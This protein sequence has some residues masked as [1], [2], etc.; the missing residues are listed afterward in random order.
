MVKKE[1]SWNILKQKIGV[2]VSVYSNPFNSQNATY[3]G[4]VVECYV[5]NTEY[6]FLHHTP[7]PRKGNILTY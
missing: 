3:Y 6:D 2:K 5:I 7:T 4:E 1:F